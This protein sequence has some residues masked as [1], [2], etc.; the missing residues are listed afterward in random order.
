MLAATR[1]PLYNP[2]KW[3]LSFTL[4]K[5]GNWSSE[6]LGRGGNFPITTTHTCP[7]QNSNIK[8]SAQNSFFD[9]RS[10]KEP[11]NEIISCP[12]KKGWILDSDQ[13][14][15]PNLYIF[16]VFPHRWLQMCSVYLWKSKTNYYHLHESLTIHIQLVTQHNNHYT[17]P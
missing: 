2:T 7:R 12:L 16:P 17:C 15:R 13:R 9:E 14:V 11:W 6:T 5:E 1:C 3:I 8:L 4:H 10:G